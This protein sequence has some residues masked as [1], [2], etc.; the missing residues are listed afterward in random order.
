MVQFIVL[1]GGDVGILYL[2]L[3]LA[4]FVRYDAQFNKAIWDQHVIPFS[5][6]F[7]L[8]VLVFFSHNLY[9][10]RA[11]KN[12]I[13]FYQ[14]LLRAIVINGILAILFFYFIPYFQITPK[15]NLLIV[16]IIVSVLFTLW[17][18][19]YNHFMRSF[20]PLRNVLIVGVTNDAVEL[21]RTIKENPQWGFRIRGFLELE[22]DE[23]GASSLPELNDV[24]RHHDLNT[25]K[26]I[27][28]NNEVATVCL[29]AN[30]DSS[31]ELSRML[32]ECIPLKITF[33]NLADFYEELTGRVPVSSLH[34][35]WFLENLRE[36]E[37]DFYEVLKRMVDISAAA[38]LLVFTL[39]L[40]PLI[41]LF[42]R[43]SG[44]G[45]IFYAQKRVGRH[46]KLFTI[47]KFR[48]MRKDADHYGLGRAEE[49]DIRITRIGKILRKTYLDELPQLLLI[50]KGDMSLVGP[51]PEQIN[52]VW[53]FTK[54][55]PHY[56]IRH[57]V[58]PGLTG[59]AQINFR[60]G[61]SKED[62]LEKL[63]Y[64][65]FYVKNRSLPLDIGI[66]IRTLSMIFKGS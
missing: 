52:L 18:Q 27:I 42:V 13:F 54:E 20:L 21:A 62:A 45:P 14:N 59:W 50:I 26:D 31:R 2:S 30:P 28:T 16:T 4:L 35:R 41:A 34:E 60:Y 55:I 12:A 46:G 48:T 38:M 57:L 66:L 39:P 6:L 5:L 17:R 43:A 32:Y 9:T 61:Y 53:E 64:D 63:R 29:A 36:S 8:W 25:L 65:L 3:F 1:L 56:H 58:T 44:P 11:L 37:R 47:M 23:N 22:Q 49:N 7:A 40:W 10:H 33:V 15:R 51:R 24:P 19:V